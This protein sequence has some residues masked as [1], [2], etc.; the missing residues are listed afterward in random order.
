VTGRE[1]LGRERDAYSTSGQLGG[2]RC[3]NH[4]QRQRGEDMDSLHD[5]QRS[6]KLRY[7]MRWKSS[8][9]RVNPL[10]I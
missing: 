3:R 2:L 4:S 10:S 7:D 6:S 8:G 5:R 1:W 9:W